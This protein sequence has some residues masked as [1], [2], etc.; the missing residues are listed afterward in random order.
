MSKLFN[1]NEIV[2]VQM[3]KDA[4]DEIRYLVKCMRE[5][6]VAATASP[7][8]YELQAKRMNYVPD[9]HDCDEKIVVEEDSSEHEE[10]GFEVGDVIYIKYRWETIASFFS[11]A[12][13]KQHLDL[14]RHNYGE[15]R[16]WISHAF[17][18]PELECLHE[19]LYV[20]ADLNKKEVDESAPAVL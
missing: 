12:G 10:Q 5:S 14:N 16:M 6:D 3:P 20:I 9:Y 2:T 4:L 19:A 1:M 13:L 8:V 15:T 11:E 7:R 17:R 18:N